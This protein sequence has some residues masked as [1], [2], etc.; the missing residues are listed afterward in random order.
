MYYLN[1]SSSELIR[2]LPMAVYHPRINVLMNHPRTNTVNWNELVG[3]LQMTYSPPYTLIL[4]S[5]KQ[6]KTFE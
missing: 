3:V 5:R 4:E 1:E 2:M 6:T